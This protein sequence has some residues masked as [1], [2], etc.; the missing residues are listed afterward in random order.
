MAVPAA[1]L[2]MQA[3]QN[4]PKVK[5]N[6]SKDV[7]T[8]LLAGSLGVGVFF[9][10]WVLA[11][12]WKRNRREVNALQP[13]NPANYAIRLKLAF[14]NDKPFGWGTD[15]EAVFQTLEEIPS[16]AMRRKVERAYKDLYGSHLSADLMDELTTQ[17]FAIAQE[18]INSKT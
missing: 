13:G 11:K 17:E 6:V 3:I 4:R 2:A 12:K 14:E 1:A 8:V 9:A 7:T 16:D 10:A 18:I 15:E 5:V